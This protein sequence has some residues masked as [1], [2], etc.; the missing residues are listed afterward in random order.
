MLADLVRRS[1]IAIRKRRGLSVP[2]V[3]RS[4]GCLPVNVYRW[5]A[6]PGV[7]SRRAPTLATV[8]VYLR[9]CDCTLTEFARELLHQ[10]RAQEEQP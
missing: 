3:A 7:T 5:E 6:G 1:L 2:D 9:A 4:A 8:E 10:L